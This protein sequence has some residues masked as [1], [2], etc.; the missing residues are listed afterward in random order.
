MISK[1]TMILIT[2]LRLMELNYR[3]RECTRLGDIHKD[4]RVQCTWKPQQLHH[5][6]ESVVQTLLKL[7]CS[8]ESLTLEEQ[9]S[10]MSPVSHIFIPAKHFGHHCPKSTVS[11][12]QP[13]RPDSWFWLQAGHTPTAWHTNLHTNCLQQRFSSLKKT[14]KISQRLMR[15]A[16]CFMWLCTICWFIY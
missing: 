7:S 4:H 10:E 11:W 6:P 13:H 5:M 16:V 12:V 15:C 2:Y 8:K 14:A 9:P 1:F 3:I